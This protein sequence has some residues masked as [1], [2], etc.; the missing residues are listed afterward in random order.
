MRARICADLGLPL[1]PDDPD[2]G[3]MD[4]VPVETAQPAK[5]EALLPSL[6]LDNQDIDPVDHSSPADAVSK[7]GLNIRDSLLFSS[8]PAPSPSMDSSVPILTARVPFLSDRTA[9]QAGPSKELGAL[10]QNQDSPAPSAFT[11]PPVTSIFAAPSSAGQ[12]SSIHP[13]PAVCFTDTPQLLESQQVQPAG[14]LSEGVSR[15]TVPQL[16]TIQVLGTSSLTDVPQPAG[17]PRPASAFRLHEA[18]LQESHTADTGDLSQ[19]MDTQCMDVD[20]DMLCSS[21]FNGCTSAL[22]GVNQLRPG[23]ILEPAHYEHVESSP[24]S[25]LL[26]VPALISN[27]L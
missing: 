22:D 9:C 15:H 25:W 24:V 3:T 18:Q 14:I 27:I 8:D 5:V 17:M 2:S 20:V 6:L 12:N 26:I 1:H 7:P 23:Q 13:I 10:P 11:P 4:T 21:D 19:G 16:Q